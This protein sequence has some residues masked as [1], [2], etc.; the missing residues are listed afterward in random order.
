MHFK[1]ERKAGP[2]NILVSPV[3]ALTYPMYLAP[4]NIHWAPRSIATREDDDI[5]DCRNS[6]MVWHPVARRYWAKKMLKV[7]KY[8]ITF[9]SGSKRAVWSVQQKS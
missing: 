2:G 5:F 9:T 4:G 8:L 1:E 3:G 7:V 6:V